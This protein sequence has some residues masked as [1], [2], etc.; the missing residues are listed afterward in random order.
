MLI[1]AVGPALNAFGVPNAAPQCTL[2]LYSGSTVIGT[3]SGWS[4]SPNATQ[5]SSAFTLTGAFILPSGSA[6]AAIL[7]SLAPGS[8]TAQATGTGAVLLEAYE[9]P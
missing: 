9:V 6:D 7:T 3:N 8:Y 2:T 4:S 1:R 5:I